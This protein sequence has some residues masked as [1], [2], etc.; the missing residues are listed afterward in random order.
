MSAVNPNTEKFP[1]YQPW[2]LLGLLAVSTVSLFWD[3]LVYTV[4]FWLGSEEYSHGI[5]LP[6]VTA[7][8]IYQKKHVFYDIQPHTRWPGIALLVAGLLG[9]LVGELSSLFIIVQYSLLLSVAGILVL[10]LGVDRFKLIAAPFMILF[11]AI[12]L[13]QFLYNNLSAELQLISSQIGVFVVR[14]FGISVFLAGNVIDL[15]SYK[16]QVVEACSGLRYLFPLMSFA[17]ICAYLFKANWWM[18]ALIFVSSMPITVLMNSFRIGVIGVLVEYWGIGAAEG[19]LHDFEGWI[20]FMACTALLAFE[21]WLLNKFF[22]KARHLTD[23]F[24]LAETAPSV[25]SDGFWNPEVKKSGVIALTLVF[26]VVIVSAVIG[27]R[28]EKPLDRELLAA[29]PHQVG[30][31]TDKRDRLDD[32]TLDALKLTDYIITN[33]NNGSNEHVNFYVAYYQSQRKGES[34]H[35]PRSCI[36]GGGWR[37]NDLSTK[38][39]PDIA[40]RQGP[41]QVNR[42]E[43][44]L[45]DTR[46]LVYYWFQQRGRVITNEYLVKWYLFWDSLTDNRTDGALVRLTTVINKG[47][48]PLLAEQRMINFAKAVNPLLP[49]YIPE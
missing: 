39:L 36:P 21:I 35:S 15:G 5:L 37:I 22:I 6:F 38:V 43:I 49:K 7:Y 47:D 26:S 11:F 14:L 27:G 2:L 30:E 10:Y 44:Q 34:A 46:Q 17:Y 12:P 20:V 40:T 16:L 24:A 8:F 45:G 32:L 18:R 41:L 4:S 29:F 25:A 1:S 31:W 48:D 23:V 42:L 33:F 3:G 28:S 13:P 19:F 9:F